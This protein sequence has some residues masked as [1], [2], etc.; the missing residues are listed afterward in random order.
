M[1]RKIELVNHAPK[2]QKLRKVA[3]YARVSSGKDAMLHSLSA[4]VSYYSDLIQ[5]Y[6]DWQCARVYADEAVTGTKDSRP[7]FDRLINDC[8]DGKVDYILTKSI[9]RFARNTVT[10][11]STVREL[12]DVGIG[13][14][15]EEQRIDTL[16]VEGEFLLT[17]LASYAQEESRSVSEN[18]KWR[19]RKGFEK[20]VPY[21]CE[22]LGY[23]LVNGKI[24]VI[25]E[26]AEL[27]RR[28]FAM[29]LDGYGTAAISKTLNAEGIKSHRGNTFSQSSIWSILRNEKHCG[30]LML[31]KYFRS[32]HITKR[33]IE[34]VGQLPRYFVADDHEPI[35]DRET[36]QAVQDE[37]KRRAD[38]FAN[39][40]EPTFSVFSSKIRCGICGKNYRRKPNCGHWHWTC[41]TYLTLGKAA[42]PSKRVPEVTLKNVCCEVLGMD[43]FDEETFAGK[44]DHI[45]AF[46]GNVLRFTLRNGAELETVWKD[47]SR[48]DSWTDE[49]KA[50]AR[51][52]SR[53][54]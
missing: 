48:R 4:Q 52:R 20:G 30:D 54:K 25:P 45:T 29:Y 22:M 21:A 43:E 46:P 44:V 8:R 19:A 16:T 37:I 32:D 10:L 31:Q 7:E 49:M 23:R 34:N 15:F 9:S 27:V 18:C 12:R 24:T 33:K 50:A 40:N 36:F 41:G 11:L 2:M 14:Y 42:C 26:E 17:V 6:S 38:M 35:I 53:R 28:I 5:K 39:S 3:A 1:E 13:I 51:E 47:H